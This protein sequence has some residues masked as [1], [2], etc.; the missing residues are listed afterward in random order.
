MR[1]ARDIT[2]L[3]GRDDTGIF[4]SFSSSMIPADSVIVDGRAV[5]EKGRLYLS[6]QI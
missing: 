3:S 5:M 2:H 6:S 4:L 1:E